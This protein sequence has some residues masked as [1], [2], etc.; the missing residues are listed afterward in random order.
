MS[1]TSICND[2]DKAIVKLRAYA[3]TKGD[4]S[5]QQIDAALANYGNSKAHGKFQ[6]FITGV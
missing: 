1:L 6:D 3:A 5:Q 2:L 4:I